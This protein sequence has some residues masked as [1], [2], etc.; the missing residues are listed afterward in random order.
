MQFDQLIA[1]ASHA[2]RVRSR[3][4][5]KANGITEEQAL[6]QTLTLIAGASGL[7]Q[8]VDDRIAARV[9]V[10]ARV[11]ERR[12]AKQAERQIKLSEKNPPSDA[13]QAWFDGSARPNPGHCRIGY[14]IKSPDGE[15][16]KH[17]QE[18][19]HGNCS[20]AEYRALLAVL[21]HAVK[22]QAHRIVIHGDSQVVINDVQQN[23][24]QVSP[25]LDD[26]RMQARQLLSQLKHPQLRWIPRHR[27]HDADA[28]S[29]Q[30]SASVP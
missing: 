10:A 20:D 28:L 13:W 6:R 2:E 18:A 25:T 7:Q 9:A 16:I 3:R 17:S 15:L 4:F 30:A 8:L 26:Y 5:A 24:D 23:A 14:V 22:L 1:I 29:Q 19:G 21:Q 11:A 12:L 27:N